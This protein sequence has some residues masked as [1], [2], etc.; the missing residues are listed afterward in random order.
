MFEFLSRFTV[1]QKLSSPVE[2]I[3]WT[4]IPGEEVHALI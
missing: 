1:R 3:S 2:M 4:T